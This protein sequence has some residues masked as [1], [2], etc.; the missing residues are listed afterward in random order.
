MAIK[1]ALILTVLLLAGCCAAR[2]G[3][4]H[5]KSL[6]YWW[7]NRYIDVE[8]EQQPWVKRDI[9]KLFAWHHKT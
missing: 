3:Y 8:A 6:T 5:G 4:N 2:L 1:T 7:L 9:E